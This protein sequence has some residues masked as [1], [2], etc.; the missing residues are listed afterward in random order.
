MKNYGH[1]LLL[2]LHGFEKPSQERVKASISRQWRQMWVLDMAIFMHEANKIM[3]NCIS[4]ACLLCLKMS[5]M[6]IFEKSQPLGF[7]L[8]QTSSVILLLVGFDFST[9][10]LHPLFFYCFCKCFMQFWWF[11][12]LCLSL[13]SK[14][15]TLKISS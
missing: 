6:Q 5:N 4:S 15:G 10:Y 1:L 14:F 7:F 3:Q 2:N 12:S 8:Y 11:S 9:F 13:F